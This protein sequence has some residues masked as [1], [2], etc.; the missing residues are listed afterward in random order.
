M[1]NLTR[2]QVIVLVLLVSFVTSLITGLVSV[3]IVLRNPDSGVPRIIERIVEKSDTGESTPIL[4]KS[5]ASQEDLVIE[6]V[7]NASPAVVSVIA[8]KD[9]PVVEQYFIN[10][11][12]GDEFFDQF[13]PEGFLIPQYRKKG[14]ERKQVSAGSG[15]FVSG[16][17][18]VVTN[19]HVIDEAGAEFTVITNGGKKYPAKILARDPI[20]DIAVLKVE[21]SGFTF[22]PLGDSDKNRVGQTV[23]A[24]GNALGEFQNTVSVGVISGL[25]RTIVAS[26]S[27]S[28]PERIG[29]VIQTDAAI[30][31]GNSGGPLLDLS[32]RAIGINVAMAQGAENIGFSIPINSVRKAVE[33]VKALGKIVYPFLG[34]RYIMIT[35]ALKEERKLGVDYGALLITEESE[36]AVLPNGPAAKAGLRDGD[37]IL[38]FG[39]VKI[40]EDSTLG[41][42]IS[43]KKVGDKVRL[44]TL[45]DSKEFEVEVQLAERPSL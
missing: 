9:V 13:L 14:T 35:S 44:K 20:Q 21:G 2:K 39:G 36:S 30:N 37:V 34:V 45:R 19:R 28:G 38:E 23:V 32:G 5:P 26:G 3:S 1:E 29:Q 12:E 15:F 10:P 22:I 6:L 43:R 24:I 4:G 17:G 27:S 33:D 18:M 11:Y 31:P 8:T 25:H 40:T 16:D 42:L 41:D 7:K